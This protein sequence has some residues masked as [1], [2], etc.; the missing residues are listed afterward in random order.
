[1]KIED[2]QIYWNRN[3]HSRSDCHYSMGSIAIQDN[4]WFEGFLLDIDLS[5]NKNQRDTGFTYGIY[6]NSEILEL[7]YCRGDLITRFQCMKENNIYIGKC[8]SIG[9]FIEK[10]NG[11]CN[12]RIKDSSCNELDLQNKT[13]L[14]KLSISTKSLEYYRTVFENRYKLIAYEG[15]YHR[16]LEKMSDIGITYPSSAYQIKYPKKNLFDL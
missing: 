13:Q 2:I 11:D 1:M 6:V 10:L 14:A 12:I 8:Y 7:F 9:A 5:A 3:L 16:N 15:I 4:K